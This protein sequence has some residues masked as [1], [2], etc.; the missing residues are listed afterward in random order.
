VLVS[1]IQVQ[2]GDETTNNDDQPLITYAIP[3]SQGFPN[4]ILANDQL[5]PTALE[6]TSEVIADFQLLSYDCVDENAVLLNGFHKEIE[7]GDFLT[8]R[9]NEIPSQILGE[10]NKGSKPEVSNP[11]QNF[12]KSKSC[13]FCGK[14]FKKPID[15][16]RHETTHTN[17]RL[18]PCSVCDK[19]FALKCTRDRHVQ[20]VHNAE[21][22]PEA[23][24]NICSKSFKSVASRNLHLRLHYGMLILNTFPNVSTNNLKKNV[25]FKIFGRSPATFVV[26]NFGHQAI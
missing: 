5:L 10:T 12:E 15:L 16:R 23:V 8:F 4:L 7:F 3:I 14:L 13:S 21:S 2:I 26:I 6:P 24:C 22:Q 9:N 20:S 1:T 18:F 11:P 17:S 19:S 25:F